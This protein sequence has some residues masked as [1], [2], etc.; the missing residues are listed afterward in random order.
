[1]LDVIPHTYYYYIHD[2]KT[3]IILQFVWPLPFL[4]MD[5]NDVSL[6]AYTNYF[7]FEKNCCEVF[8]ISEY[9]VISKLKRLINN[10]ISTSY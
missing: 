3:Q 9:N 6:G 2:L 5:K 4:L 8:S 7:S 1:M 10:S